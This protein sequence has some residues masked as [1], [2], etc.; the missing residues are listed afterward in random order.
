M[1][2]LAFH[3]HVTQPTPRTCVHACLS[4]VTG[5]SIN[6]LIDRLGDYGQGREHY[7]PILIE[8]RL[9]PVEVMGN[10][11]PFP[12]QGVYL[13]VVPSLNLPHMTHLVVVVVD[14]DGYHV[15]DPNQG[16][17]NMNVFDR[18]AYIKQQLIV[19]SVFYLNT[20]LLTTMRNPIAPVG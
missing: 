15:Y 19:V 20:Q 2:R 3:G 6:E 12:Y 16:R 10:F 11:D 18:D 4:M 13:V 9:F 14:E 17:E 1:T 8:H 5:Q 7:L